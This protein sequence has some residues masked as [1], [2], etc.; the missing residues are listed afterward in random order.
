MVSERMELFMINCVLL[1]DIYYIL[2]TCYICAVRF[3][4][5]K[6]I[7]KRLL[8][9]NIEQLKQSKVY[10]FERLSF[11]RS[12]GKYMPYSKV[13]S[14]L[15]VWI[16]AYFPSRCFSSINICLSE[17]LDFNFMC[18]RFLLT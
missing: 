16:I 10:I 8:K 3:Q 1:S 4:V 2:L 18:S 14:F 5:S 7:W 9:K 6:I 12:S 11:G 13:D 17:S 15:K